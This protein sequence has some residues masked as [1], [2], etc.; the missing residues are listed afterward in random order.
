MFCIRM[1]FRKIVGEGVI[2]QAVQR[3][4]RPERS[5]YIFDMSVSTTG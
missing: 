5:V 4:A 2:Q 3:A 1:A